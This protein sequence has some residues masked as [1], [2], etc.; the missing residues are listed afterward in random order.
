[1]NMV[2]L[3]NF[4]VTRYSIIKEGFWV[5]WGQLLTAIISLVGL[6]LITEFT[7]PVVFGEVT[8]WLSVMV[9]LKSVFVTPVSNYQLRY[10]PQYFYAN[11]IQSFNTEIKKFY[12]KFFFLAAGI[13]VFLITIASIVKIEFINWL[14]VPGLLIFFLLDGSKSYFLNIFSSERKQ[15]ILSLFTIGDSILM[16]AIILLALF[17]NNSTLSYIT[18]QASSAVLTFF[19]LYTFFH[20]VNTKQI[21][22]SGSNLSSIVVD[23]KNYTIPFIPIAILSWILNLSNRYI[24]NSYS[25]LVDVGIFTA[26]FAISSKPF[27]FLGGL[28]TNFFRPILFEKQSKNEYAKSNKIFNLWLITNGGLGLLIVIVLFFW[29]SFISTILLAKDFRQNSA[30]LFFLIGLGY[31]FASMFQAIEYRFMS[32]GD[33]KSILIIYLASALIYISSNLLFIPK[34]GLIGAGSAILVSFL[35]QF[36]IGLLYLNRTLKKK[37]KF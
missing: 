11:Q 21:H 2:I 3:R 29:G 28:L 17:L 18:G 8:L 27:L 10:Y 12:K 23:F 9:L 4:L 31:L 1:M 25:S 22:S 13:F 26:A 33:T 35:F 36:V 16:F 37:N 24:L 19:L 15:F 34:Q 30:I 14:L 32:F 6:R 5:F 20:L 7:N